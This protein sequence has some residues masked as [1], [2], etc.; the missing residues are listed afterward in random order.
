TPWP[1]CGLFRRTGWCSARRAPSARPPVA[2]RC[3]V[4]LPCVSTGILAPGAKEC[5]IPGP[6]DATTRA[7]SVHQS[8]LKTLPGTPIADDGDELNFCSTCAFSTACLSEGYDKS[9]LRDLHVL[10]EHVGPYREGDHIFRE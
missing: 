1:H 3:C 6:S 8:P 2:G 9:Q 5:A 10:V 7:A 4:S